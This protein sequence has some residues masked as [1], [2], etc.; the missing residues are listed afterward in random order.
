MKYIKLCLVALLSL[1][2]SISRA[3]QPQNVVILVD[4]SGSIPQQAR[5]NT[6]EVVKDILL[7]RRI[8]DP[9]F[10]YEKDPS[11]TLPVTSA[12][13]VSNGS[14]ILLIP[15]GEK[16]TSDYVKETTISNFPNDV[17]NFIDINYPTVFKDN[18]TFLTLAKAK[19]AQQAKNRGLSNFLLLVIS[20]GVND[21]TAGKSPNY[22]GYEQ[23]LVENFNSKSNP[24]LEGS[25][26][27][28]VKFKGSNDF[29]IPLR[30]IDIKNYKAPPSP[31][32]TV[33]P[34]T[35][36]NAIDSSLSIEFPAP[37]SAANRKKPVI[38][39][40][41]TA[42]ISWL[43]KNCPDNM[44]YNVAITQVEGG[45][46]KDPSSRGITAPSV[47]KNL[48]AG[49]YKITVSGEVSGS[50]K[51]VSSATTYITVEG[52][53]GLWWLWL[54][55]IAAVVAVLLY[56]NKEKQKKKLRD[57]VSR[58]KGTKSTSSILDSNTSNHS[59]L[60]EF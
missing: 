29:K 46:F 44:K 31:T 14:R 40:S 58:S 23:Q 49:T 10:Y 48:P 22:T 5:T 30:N 12:P 6:K 25:Y 24:I 13:L 15:F 57:N 35:T 32:T 42:S 55:L 27:G 9:N 36:P 47:S 54:L 17:T 19:A 56:L 3:Q 28:Y 34:V 33:P 26:D 38:T 37:Y 21:F 2:F 8:S 52:S 20:D 50:N 39:K 60:N 51:P 43:C 45:N 41:N 11:S 7:G 16:L 59:T 53:G 4:V 18:F 1:A